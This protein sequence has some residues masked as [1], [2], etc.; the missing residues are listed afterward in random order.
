MS[1]MSSSVIKQHNCKV[2]SKNLDRLCNPR[3]KD[4]SPLDRKY[5]YIYIYIYI[6]YTYV[7]N[8]NTR[9]SL[10]KST[11]KAKGKYTG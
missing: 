4:S 3:N 11:M 9:Q 8:E 6:L 7:R 2:S 1:N 5:I 10:V